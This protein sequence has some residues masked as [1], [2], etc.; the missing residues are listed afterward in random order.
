[1]SLDCY[2]FS[3]PPVSFGDVGST[4]QNPTAYIIYAQC[5]LLESLGTSSV[6]NLGFYFG[7]SNI[8]MCVMRCLGNGTQIQY[9]LF[10]VLA[11]CTS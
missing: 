6:S 7:F 11:T 5:P 10:H 4:Y 2:D 1:M 8:C 3:V 9:T